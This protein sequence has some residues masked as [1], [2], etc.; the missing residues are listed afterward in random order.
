MNAKLKSLIQSSINSISNKFRS[1][2]DYNTAHIFWQEVSQLD[3]FS[4]PY[5]RKIIAKEL[6]DFEPW[7]VMSVQRY[8]WNNNI[9]INLIPKD[10]H[11]RSISV[12][13][14]WSLEC[15]SPVGELETTL[16]RKD[17]EELEALISR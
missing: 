6:N 11:E 4:P 2:V 15:Y 16:T 14:D 9:H 13:G 5:R 12:C 8:P 7:E 1:L 3:E 17:F 10:G